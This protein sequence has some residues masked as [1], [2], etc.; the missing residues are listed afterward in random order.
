MNNKFESIDRNKLTSLTAPLKEFLDEMDLYHDLIWLTV[1]SISVSQKLPQ[2]IAAIESVEGQVQELQ[3]Q[4]KRIDKIAALANQE[5]DSGFHFLYNQA[6]VYLYSQLEGAIKRFIMRFF[7]IEGVIE[8]F[9]SIGKV[10][11]S[12]SEYT[13][14]NEVERLEYI[15]QQYEKNEARGIQYGVTRFESLLEPIGFGGEVDQ[16]ISRDIYELSQVRNNLIHRGGIIDKYLL[17]SC[18][19]IKMPLGSKIGLEKDQYERYAIASVKYLSVIL[20]RLGEIRGKDM[21]ELNV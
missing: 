15:F 3:V 12:I 16:S 17:D 20:V 4:K 13:S 18:P 11:I 21:S 2:A 14:L 8:N 7:S 19:W 1:N 6:V 9:D 5:I 10:K